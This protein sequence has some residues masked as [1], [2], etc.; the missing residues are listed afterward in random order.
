MPK[1]S[2]A[3]NPESVES[4]GKKKINAILKE[5]E[6]CENVQEKAG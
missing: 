6:D 3:E 1:H 2:E 5:I 4:T